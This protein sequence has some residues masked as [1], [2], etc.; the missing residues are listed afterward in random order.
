MDS[1]ENQQ[2][3][4]V[5]QNVEQPDDQQNP[6]SKNT[7]PNYFS[8]NKNKILLV[9]IALLVIPIIVLSLYL[10]VDILNTNPGENKDAIV[11]TQDK[12]KN[13][14]EGNSND[15]VV[16]KLSDNR[17]LTFKD[18]TFISCA[19]G[20]VESS[21]PIL[22]IYHG[23][24][25]VTRGN[26]W[27]ISIPLGNV[28]IGKIYEFPTNNNEVFQEPFIVVRESLLE[29]P[30]HSSNNTKGTIEITKGEGCNVGDKVE[31][32]I[33]ANLGI[34]ADSN[35]EDIKVI[36]LFSGEVNNNESY[37]L[38]KWG[39][40]NN[41]RRRS[42]LVQ[43]LNSIESYIVDN[44]GTIPKGITTS[45]KLISNTGSNICSDIVDD[46]IPAI[47]SD[48]KAENGG[49]AITDDE[50]LGEYN[51]EY[52]ISK[53]LDDKITVSAPLAENGVVI[54]FTR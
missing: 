27:F 52:A 2:P 3:A 13:S 18:N 14:K 42:D 26:T 22:E 36:G 6:P 10:L 25:F 4:Y 12:Q 48:P 19:K 8:K 1:N 50:C 39:E 46:F 33:D 5:D 51:T 29:K 31:F 49:S 20:S 21:N 41:I 45:E 17:V 38:W 32:S 16:T 40:S 43:I 47:P 9:L 30:F 35:N 53:S 23:V 28:K 34:V 37:E 44:G 11:Q 7:P 24:D 54:Q 15:I